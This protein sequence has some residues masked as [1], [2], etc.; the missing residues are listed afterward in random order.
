MDD[1]PTRADEVRE[2]WKQK[3]KPVTPIERLRALEKAVELVAKATPGPWRVDDTRDD[4][5]V[6]GRPARKCKRYGKA[7]EWAVAKVEDQDFDFDTTGLNSANAIAIASA[8]N[9]IREHGSALIAELG[10]EVGAVAVPPFRNPSDY[11]DGSYGP[12][13][14]AAIWNSCVHECQR[15]NDA[16]M[17]PEGG[18]D[19]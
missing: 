6:V 9:F 13:D 15:L 17:R 4:I 10:Q 5:E 12:E 8:V 11:S 7:G 3:E 18:I 1:Y 16:T 19:E 2:A 14:L